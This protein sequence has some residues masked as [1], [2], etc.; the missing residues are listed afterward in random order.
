MMRRAPLYAADLSGTVPTL[1][2]PAATSAALLGGV[3]SPGRAR[4]PA[5][6]VAAACA[7]C[8]SGSA[9]KWVIGRRRR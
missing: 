7:L 2:P 1:P 5:A 6:R 4:A 3:P 9:D 8:F